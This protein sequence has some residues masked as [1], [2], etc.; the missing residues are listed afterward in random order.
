MTGHFFPPHLLLLTGY[1]EHISFDEF[2]RR[3]QALLPPGGGDSER[4]SKKDDVELVLFSQ[5]IDKNL[6]RMGLSQV[7]FRAGTLARLDRIRE[8]KMHGTMVQIQVR[9]GWCWR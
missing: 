8:D 1:P 5:S 6:Y 4:T 9:S 2:S 7:F 3:Y